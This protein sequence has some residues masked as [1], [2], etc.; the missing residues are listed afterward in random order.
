MI[1]GGIQQHEGEDHADR[2]L[3]CAEDA[4]AAGRET[5]IEGSPDFAK[6]SLEGCDGRID[7][8]VGVHSG[9]IVASVIGDLKPRYAL[10]GDTINAAARMESSSVRGRIRVTQMAVDT[11]KRPREHVIEKRGDVNIKGEGMMI[12]YWVGAR[13]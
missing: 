5:V 1:A 4:V 2:I 6:F 7:I 8:R 10:F 12:T 9:P 11:L 3:K 13:G